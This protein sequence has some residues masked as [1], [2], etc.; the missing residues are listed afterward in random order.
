MSKRCV[1][2][3]II[4][5]LGREHP[6]ERLEEQCRIHVEARERLV[7]HEQ[8]GIVQERRGEQHALAHPFENAAIV[9]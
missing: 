2:K 9:E 7:E 5:P 3:G 1:L 8:V 6:D 4:R